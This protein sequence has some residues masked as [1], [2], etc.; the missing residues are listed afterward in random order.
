MKTMEDRRKE[1]ESRIIEVKK[2]IL[3]HIDRPLLVKV[4]FD[5]M[6]CGC[7]RGCY[8]NQLVG[9]VISGSMTVKAAVKLLLTME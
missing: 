1:A 3:S 6:K 2:E 7:Q 5:V 4:L 8:L 9:D